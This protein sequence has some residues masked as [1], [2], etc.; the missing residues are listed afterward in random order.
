MWIE[1][2]SC[3][4]IMKHVMDDAALNPPPPPAWYPDYP[5]TVLKITLQHVV[6]RNCSRKM[7]SQLKSHRESRLVSATINTC[8]R[9]DK[10]QIPQENLPAPYVGQNVKKK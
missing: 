10:H 8:F 7:K 6:K 1:C 3:I 5:H 2:L 9:H 4:C